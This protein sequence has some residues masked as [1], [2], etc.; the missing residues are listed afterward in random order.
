MSV[1]LLY[2]FFCLLYC[3]LSTLRLM[4]FPIYLA[5]GFECNY[6]NMCV[7]LFDVCVYVGYAFQRLTACIIIYQNYTAYFWKVN[8]LLITL[9]VCPVLKH[10]TTCVHIPVHL[11]CQT[12]LLNLLQKMQL[13]DKADSN[14]HIHN[15]AWEA[16]LY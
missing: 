7:Y 8:G 9:S 1:S 5:L 2:H 12:N 16:L 10:Y 6:F 15:T 14:H 4:L 3:N 13:R 11:N